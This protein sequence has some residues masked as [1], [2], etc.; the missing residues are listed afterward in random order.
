M[1]ITVKTLADAA[2]KVIIAEVPGGGQDDI[3]KFITS[4]EKLNSRAEAEE[5]VRHLLERRKKNIFMLG[6]FLAKLQMNPA[7]WDNSYPNFKDYIESVL[8]IGYWKAMYAINLYKKL[9]CL[10]LPWSAF[11]GIGWVKLHLLMKIVTKDNV[12][13]WVEKARP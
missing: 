2:P 6:G 7:W 5:S 1:S 11:G 4:L 10:G 8:G 3:A 12:A 13:E 9:L